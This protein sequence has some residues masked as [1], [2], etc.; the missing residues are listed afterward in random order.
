ML[1]MVHKL[2]INNIWYQHSNSN[3]IATCSFYLIQTL[4]A[5]LCAFN[6]LINYFLMDFIVWMPGSSINLHFSWGILYSA[7]SRLE[8]PKHEFAFHDIIHSCYRD[9]LKGGILFG[10]TLNPV[11]GG[12]GF[13]YIKL[14]E[15]EQLPSVWE[16]PLQHGVTVQYTAGCV[17]IAV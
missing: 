17:M 6:K 12:P 15:G 13:I 4:L 14:M 8:F 10:G 1:A 2:L 9:T 7:N 16:H 3:C 5:A 11:S